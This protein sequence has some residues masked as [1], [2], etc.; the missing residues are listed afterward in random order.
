MNNSGKDGSVTLAGREFKRVKNGLDE[1]EI[2]SF[3]DELIKERD[4]LAQSQHHIG[5]LTKLAETTI[6]EA[7]RLAKQIKA[8]AAEQVKA[9][10][11]A[12]I[13]KAREEA[14]QAAEMK[15]AEI[16][17][18]ANEKADAIQT[19]AEKKSALLLESEREKI[20]DELR[21]FVNQQVGYLLEKLETLKQQAT[22]IQADFDNKLSQVVEEKMAE[23]AEIAREEKTTETVEIAGQ[24]KMAETSEMAREEKTPETTEISGEKKTLETAEVAGEKSVEITATAEDRNATAT[25][26]DKMPAESPE[27]PVGDVD[28]TENSFDLAAILQGDD[29]TELGE[30]QWEV[31]IL[32]PVEI[33]KVMEIMAHLDQ[34]RQ[35]ANTEM[36]VPQVDTPS[37]LVFLREEMDFIDML[38]TIPAVA[39]VEE[40]PD[41]GNVANGKLRKARISLSENKVPREEK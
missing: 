23:T 27:Q 4:E 13:D 15:Q 18:M 32:P 19:Q 35:V 25:K 9:E 21:N 20:R 26:E 37:I 39:Y 22:I 17:K 30:P 24:E 7:D 12:I 38:R 33:T 11:A 6:V 3:I 2:K 5:S 10:S 28:Q 41:D 14:Q 40:V 8:E 29:H 1:A 36:I 16:L 34:L 31:A